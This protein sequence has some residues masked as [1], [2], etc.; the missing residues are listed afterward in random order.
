MKVM[1]IPNAIGALIVKATRRLGDNRKSEDHLKYSVIKINLNTKK[2]S[3]DLRRLAVT[4]T[5]VVGWKNSQRNNNNNNNNN[6]NH[7]PESV[8]ENEMHKIFWDFERQINHLI[9]ARRLDSYEKKKKKREEN[10]P[11]SGF[12]L[13]VDHGMKIKE[14]EK[15][16]KYLDLSRGLKS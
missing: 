8:L 5:P 6:N 15:R 2:S 4:K 1:V 13:P 16:D 14:N 3:G 12:C 11:T 10:L 9:A 7:K